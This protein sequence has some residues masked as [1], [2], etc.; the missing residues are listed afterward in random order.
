MHGHGGILVSSGQPF[1]EPFYA[2]R[3]AIVAT[4]QLNGVSKRY[5]RVHAVQDAS[6]QVDD[7]ALGVVLGA[8]GSGKT[9][10]LRLIAGLET[11]DAGEISL[12][13][14][15][16]HRRPPHQRNLAMTFQHDALLPHLTVAENLQFP[17]RM[18]R[19][20]GRSKGAL[21]KQLEQIT[22]LLP[23]GDLLRRHPDQLSGGQRQLVSLGRALI[24][25]P[26]LL[27]LDEPFAHLDAPLRQQM[28]E[29]LLDVH[30]ARKWTMLFVTHD[31]AE[32]LRLAEQLVILDG[33]AVEYSGDPRAAYYHPSHRKLASFLGGR[34]N[35][36]PLASLPQR[37]LLDAGSRGESG[38]FAVRPELVSLT[39]DVEAN[40]VDAERWR[41][42]G[43]VARR[44]WS[45]VDTL[46]EIHTEELVVLVRTGR[47]DLAEPGDDVVVEIQRS[48]VMYFD[49][50]FDDESIV[51]GASTDP[52]HPT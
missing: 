12:G 8:S 43:R 28:R 4:L 51:S 35:V 40:D 3:L 27:L 42:R 15:L 14:E 10:L 44:E 49:D 1:Y 24:G 38:V 16:I 7:G 19:A 9:T 2:Q 46:W 34:L 48:D 47:D 13:G 5:G 41:L 32:A 52:G 6:L 31:Q 33:G 36:W 11:P 29:T 30:R 22:E 37:W 25:E 50:D 39:Q 18:G 45:G 21:A 23:L 26:E 17:L 20:K